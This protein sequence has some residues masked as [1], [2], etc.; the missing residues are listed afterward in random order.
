MTFKNLPHPIAILLSS[1]RSGDREAL[2]RVF[3][4]DAVVREGAWRCEGIAAVGQWI[5]GLPLD[6]RDGLHPINVAAR[7]GEMIV[8]FVVHAQREPADLARP[9]RFDWCLSVR[10]DQV[11]ALTIRQTSVP[12]LPGVVADFVRA[13]NAFDLEA[14]LATFAEDAL[15]ND[16]FTTYAGKKAV[17]QWA[18]EAMI[19]DRVTMHVVDAGRHY[20][21]CIVGANVDGDF[22]K[23]GLPDP[24]VLTFYFSLFQDKIVRLIVLRAC[25]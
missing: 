6:E 20:E 23:A 9:D 22:D 16:Q 2:R 11:T 13:T 15:V 25:P 3:A 14:L 10:H 18:D 5:D 19:G 12:E 8:T 24:F 21:C 17:K 4:A 7:E 1:L